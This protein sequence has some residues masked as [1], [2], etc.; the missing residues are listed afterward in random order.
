MV[1]AVASAA[2]RL[3]TP[4]EEP[5]A[6]SPAGPIRV[7][8]YNLHQGFDTD[9]RLGPEALASVIEAERP[10][11]LAL[12]EV[13]RGW[14]VTGGLDLQAWMTRRLGMAGRFAGTGDPQWGNAVLTRLPVLGSEYHPLPPDDLP[15]RRGVIDVTLEAGGGPLRILCLHLHHRRA[16]DEIRVRQTEE[17]LRIW[18]DSP[19]TLL[20]GDFN[21][22]PGSAS[23]ELLRAAG[24]HD[25]SVLL[26]P[27]QRGTTAQLDGRQ[28]DWVFA[29]PDLTFEATT[30]PFSTASDHLP[31]ATTVRISP[32]R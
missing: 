29:T 22:V 30:V 31:V 13:A 10:D 28:I 17:L 8:T 26:P 19:A 7:M 3:L 21:A 15:L 11:V 27:A 20:L 5:A 12:Q 6:S 25:A 14:L 16:D 23:I 24:L 4:P 9:G 18:S 2:T 1:A 32:T